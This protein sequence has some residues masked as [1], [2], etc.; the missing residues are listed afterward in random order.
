MFNYIDLIE[1]SVCMA[2]CCFVVMLL[3]VLAGRIFKKFDFYNYV[4]AFLLLCWMFSFATFYWGFS[5]EF[6]IS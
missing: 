5:Y 1:I 3:F 6:F 2:F 4:Q